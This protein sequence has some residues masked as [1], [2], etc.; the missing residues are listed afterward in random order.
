M[1]GHLSLLRAQIEQKGG[2]RVNYL[3]LFL[4]WD[5]CLLLLLDSGALGFW[6]SDSGTF[7]SSPFCSQA[8][9]LGPG[10]IPSA[11]LVLRPSDSN[12][13]TLSTHLVLCLSE[14]SWNPL[15]SITMWACS[16]NKSLLRDR[17]ISY[18]FCFSGDPD[19]CRYR[20]P[21]FT[22]LHVCLGLYICNCYTFI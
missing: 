5:I 16:Y 22:C 14:S 4:S 13:I 19:E 18:W 11:R 15:A 21:G 3:F 17:H 2:E 1:G 7:T 20:R 12:W 6:P 8:F 10:V 9:S